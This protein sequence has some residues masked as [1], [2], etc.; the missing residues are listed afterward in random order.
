MGGDKREALPG[1]VSLIISVF[2][3]E[4]CNIGFRGKTICL[5][6]DFTVRMV[7]LLTVKMGRGWRNA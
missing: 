5:R 7:I 6:K 4:C 3:D 1:R 2:L